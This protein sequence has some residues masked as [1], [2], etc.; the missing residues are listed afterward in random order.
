[1]GFGEMGVSEAWSPHG[2][3]N[4]VVHFSAFFDET[5]LRPMDAT[6]ENQYPAY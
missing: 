1:M 4:G 2:A 6:E 5:A 3:S